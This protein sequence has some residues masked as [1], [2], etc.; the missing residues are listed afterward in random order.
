[1]F[2]QPIVERTTVANPREWTSN[3]DH[4]P[5]VRL[6]ILIMIKTTNNKKIEKTFD[7]LILIRSKDNKIHKNNMYVIYTYNILYILITPKAIHFIPRWCSS[8][9]LVVLF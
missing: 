9:A 7:Q 3:P 1:M 2:Y 5:L 4:L 6:I 8:S